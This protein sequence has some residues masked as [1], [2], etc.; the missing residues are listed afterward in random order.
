M[1]RYTL[2]QVSFN[3]LEMLRHA[4]GIDLNT[5]TKKWG[6]RNYYCAA[7]TDCPAWDRLCAQGLAVKIKRCP[8]LGIESMYHATVDGAWFAGLSMKKAE[9]VGVKVY[10]SGRP[11]R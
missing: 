7:D 5:S 4:L 1:N 3:D 8:E 2:L 10:L 9:A 6:Y 11:E